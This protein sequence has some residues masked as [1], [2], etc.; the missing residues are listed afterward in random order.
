MGR[1]VNYRGQKEIFTSEFGPG[2]AVKD[3]NDILK[4]FEL[5]FNNEVLEVL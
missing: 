4:I 5:C 1:H 2:G 3:S